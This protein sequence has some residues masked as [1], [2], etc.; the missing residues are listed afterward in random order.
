[1]TKLNA[2]GSAPLVYSTF[3][4]GNGA[5]RGFG[6]AFDASGNAYVTG[7][8]QSNELPDDRRGL[9]HRARRQR[10]LRDEAERDRYCAPRPTRPSSGEAVAKPASA[11]P[12]TPRATP[13]SPERQPRPPS[14]RPPG[15]S[16][17]T[18]NGNGDAFVTKLNAT[19]SAPLAYSTFLGGSNGDTGQGIAVD[20]PNS[21]Y[22]TGE[23]NS[24][25]ANP[26]P[27]TAGAFD[28]TFNTDGD[29]FV[30]KLD[31]VAAGG[32]ATLAINDVLAER[33]QRPHDGVHVHGHQERLDDGT[34]TVDL[35]DRKR[36]RYGWG[37]LY[38]QHRLREPERDAQLR[39]DPDDP[40]DHDPRLRGHDLRAERDLLRQP[41]EPDRRDD[42]RRPGRGHDRQRRRRRRPWRSTTSRR[43]RATPARRRSR[44]RSRRAA[45]RRATATV[46]LRHRQRHR[47]RRRACAA[48]PTT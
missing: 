14:R 6:I 26:F 25:G 32:A 37:Y 29:A 36:H 8:T 42:H 7:E 18:Y 27:T 33:G 15:R 5:D 28:T 44:S 41:D 1:M 39:P 47:D 3:L 38:R 10:R 24:G 46:D 30:T 20:A 45:R 12:S 31:T 16:T 21:V 9:R 48:A 34:A 13:T 11:S 19:G 2:T 43:T 17:R 22:V 23:T 4:G 40:D 35:R